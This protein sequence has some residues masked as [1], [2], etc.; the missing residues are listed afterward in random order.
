MQ[1]DKRKA[2]LKDSHAEQRTFSARTLIAAVIITVLT[3]A[4]VARL[5]QLQIFEHE[6]YAALSLG[7]S[8]RIEAL[9]PTRGLIYDRRGKVLAE[10]LPAWQLELTAEQVLN[11]DATLAE[12]TRLGFLEEQDVAAIRQRIRDEQRFVPVTLKSRVSEQEIARFAIMRPRFPGV[13]IKARL[14]RHY[15]Q[16]ELAVHALGYV[17]GIST[18]N[19]E[20]LEEPD[21]YAATR[22]FGK[23]GIERRYETLLHGTTGYHQILTNAHGRALESVPGEAPT[24][25]MNLHLNLDIN[26]Q[27]IAEAELAGRR[28]SVVAINPQN[29]EVLV[30]ASSPGF[31]PNAFATGLGQREYADVRDDL[32]RPL[33]NR[34][35]LGRY[36]PGSTIKPILALAALEQ[37]VTTFN[38]RIFCEGAFS[39]PGSSHRYRDWKPEGHGLVDLHDSIAESCDVYFYELS[40]SLG[41]NNMHE[42]LTRFGL[43]SN[44]G[45]DINGEKPGLIP[46]EDWKRRNFT[47]R[48]DQTWFPGET[49]I[50]SI[51]QGYML[52][53]PL[54][55]AHVTATIAMR[56]K[57]FVPRLLH[58]SEDPISGERFYNEPV[59]LPAVELDN[60]LHWEAVLNAMRDVLQGPTGTARAAGAN[61]DYE[62]A[63]KSGTAQVFSVAQEDEYDEEDM[64]ILLRDHALFIAF[65]PLDEPTIAVALVI[66]NGSS[67]SR[68]AAPVARRIMDAWLV[69]EDAATG[70]LAA[71]EH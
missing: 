39:L 70:T 69:P 63:G 49:V 25:G 66:E 57:R 56:G 55:L 30:L 19:L 40:Q 37:H 62:M 42:Y 26:L 64:D 32:A 36:P 2:P 10:N 9:S 24:P 16:G 54:Q 27:R 50:A 8:L 44:T 33:F 46:S 6:Q 45:I 60:N 59:E 51:G 53:T 21:N 34:A 35:I 71:N 11:V 14:I 3:G 29:G 47:N 17:S 52:A 67:G 23:T 38:H 68:V 41:I 20:G 22:Q 13:D 48:A 12:L 5:V 15:P 43:G 65:A 1:S 7:N 61:A 18:A 31:D 58:Y 28:G 4:L